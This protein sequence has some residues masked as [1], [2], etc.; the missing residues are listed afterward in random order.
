MWRNGKFYGIK[1]ILA[2]LALT[3]IPLVIFY[4]IP[5]VL[6][7]AVMP[8]SIKDKLSVTLIDKDTTVKTTKLDLRIKPPPLKIAIV[9]SGLN[10]T[11]NDGIQLCDS[12]LAVVD[13]TGTGIEDNMGHGTNVTNIIAS[14][15]K[16]LNY[17]FYIF[18]AFDPHNQAT[19]IAS[20]IWALDYVYLV[21]P[22]VVNIS[23][24][25]PDYLRFEYNVIEDILERNIKI[26][27][28]EVMNQRN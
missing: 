2:I 4:C 19:G 1:T 8:N 25:G 27:S 5:M 21:R 14:K 18:K 11:K 6:Y 22:F 28:A 13:F 3:F 24:G 12:A 15:L 16:G 20:L 17:C 26:N 9:D 7:T 23:A 10:R